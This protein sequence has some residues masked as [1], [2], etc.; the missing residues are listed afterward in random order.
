MQSTIQKETSALSIEARDAEPCHQ[1]FRPGTPARV[2][3][4]E[5][6]IDV[7]LCAEAVCA[8]CGHEGLEFRPYHRGDCYRIMA[9]CSQC[10]SVEEF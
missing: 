2:S 6:Q 4:V 9:A 10:G 5:R 1:G 7:D 8:G 3:A